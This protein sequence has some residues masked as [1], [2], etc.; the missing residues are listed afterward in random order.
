LS[1]GVSMICSAGIGLPR[2]MHRLSTPDGDATE[3]VTASTIAEVAPEL[4]D[5]APAS[6][7]PANRPSFDPQVTDQQKAGG[8]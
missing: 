8:P 1:A 7:R 2:E 6:Y 5:L 4:R 3:A